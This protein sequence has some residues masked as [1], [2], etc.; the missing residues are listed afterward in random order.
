[1]KK[2]VSLILSQDARNTYRHQAFTTH[3]DF[4]LPL[5]MGCHAQLLEDIGVVGVASKEVPDDY[6]VPHE[7]V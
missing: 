2:L 3:V 1:M 4:D 7:E 5:W 6:L